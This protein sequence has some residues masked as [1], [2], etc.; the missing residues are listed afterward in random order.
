MYRLQ[1]IPH[2][3]RSYYTRAAFALLAIWDQVLAPAGT[4]FLSIIVSTSLDVFQRARSILRWALCKVGVDTLENIPCEGGDASFDTLPSSQA[5]HTANSTASAWTLARFLSGLHSLQSVKLLSTVIASGLSC[6]SDRY[7]PPSLGQADMT[8]DISVQLKDTP[9]IEARDTVTDKSADRELVCSAGIIADSDVTFHYSDAGDIL[10]APVVREAAA[11]QAPP[12]VCTCQCS[13]VSKRQ[14]PF[15]NSSKAAVTSSPGTTENKKADGFLSSVGSRYQ[16]AAVKA[17]DS[18]KLSPWVIV[19]QLAMMLSLLL[20]SSGVFGTLMRTTAPMPVPAAE[21]AP[22]SAIDTTMFSAAAVLETARIDD[23]PVAQVTASAMNADYVENVGDNDTGSTVD[24]LQYEV[25]SVADRV[26]EEEEEAAAD[27]PSATT[28]VEDSEMSLS[29]RELYHTEDVLEMATIA[30]LP[31]GS[32]TERYLKG[33]FLHFQ[34]PGVSGA[35]EQEEEEAVHD[36]EYNPEEFFAAE[37]EIEREGIRVLSSAMAAIAED[38]HRLSIPLL[39]SV[40]LC[41]TGLNVLGIDTGGFHRLHDCIDNEMSRYERQRGGFSFYQMDAYERRRNSF[42]SNYD[43]KYSDHY[44]YAKKALQEAVRV[45]QSLL[46][47]LIELWDTF[48]TCF[49]KSLMSSFAFF[50]F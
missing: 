49:E 8:N 9:A 29:R 35:L 5:Q 27:L 30:G 46:P 15:S 45:I 31:E 24:F 40:A 25:L 2:F 41:T 43:I 38:D 50:Y 44:D 17:P 6:V 4:S 18:V 32:G 16:D 20:L 47:S 22:L 14:S 23:S 1:S 42:W 34:P 33:S 37:L 28:Y 48:V 7:S 11:A 12:S 39:H 26:S 21:P 13:A 36:L 19:V 3:L 10:E